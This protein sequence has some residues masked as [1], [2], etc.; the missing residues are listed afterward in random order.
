MEALREPFLVR[1]A[2]SSPG[3]PSGRPFPDAKAP[4]VLRRGP[5]VRFAGFA[6]FRGLSARLAYPGLRGIRPNVA[7]P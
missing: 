4:G 5:C 2:S 7:C 6:R 3:T 1:V